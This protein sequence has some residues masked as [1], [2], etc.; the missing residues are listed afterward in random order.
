MPEYKWLPESCSYRRIHLGKKLPSWHPLLTGNRKIMRQQGITVCR[1][2]VPYQPIP[3]RKR[4][5]F[6]LKVKAI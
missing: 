3:K 6:I 2:A 1:L 4:D 5:K